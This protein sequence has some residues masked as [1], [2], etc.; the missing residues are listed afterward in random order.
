MK[1][2]HAVLSVQQSSI[3]RMPTL[4]SPTN[5]LGGSDG[6]SAS[7]ELGA[8]SEDDFR[9]GDESSASHETGLSSRDRPKRARG[10]ADGA[11]EVAHH[12][13]SA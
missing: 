1:L 2:V 11:A 12:G 13:L 8:P 4:L 7:Q 5:K 9:T 3:V 6:L 10:S